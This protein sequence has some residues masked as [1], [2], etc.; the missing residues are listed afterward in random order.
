MHKLG[1]TPV[2]LPT[3]PIPSLSQPGRKLEP[4]AA[5]QLLPPLALPTTAAASSAAVSH[6]PAAL[7]SLLALF[8]HCLARGQL[9][10][11]GRLLVLA[12]DGAGGTETVDSTLRCVA[13]PDPNP[14]HTPSLILVPSDTPF[15]RT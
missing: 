12:C 13:R 1:T 9:R 7:R 4:S 3:P 2:S 5:A 14:C 8:E 6:T 11:A 10:G 15:N